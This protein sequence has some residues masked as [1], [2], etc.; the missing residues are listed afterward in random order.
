VR[1]GTA[2][3]ADDGMFQ[4][5][6][7]ILVVDDDPTW[8][9]IV[10]RVLARA[11]CSVA[12]ANN[13]R[14]ALRMKSFL[15]SVVVSD[16][17][18]RLAEGPETRADGSWRPAIAV[19]CDRA[20]LVPGL[21]GA[22]RIFGEADLLECALS[23]LADAS[24]SRPVPFSLG[25]LWTLLGFRSRFD[26]PGGSRLICPPDSEK[27]SRVASD[28]VIASRGWVAFSALTRRRVPLVAIVL[29]SLLLV[30][31]APRLKGI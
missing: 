9:R 22:F 29:A 15:P 25:R 6:S 31:L 4:R 19:T 26:E 7:R 10:R 12:T 27:S 3:A 23:A 28:D 2:I 30:R 1:R 14:G 21:P 5:G 24:P 17:N 11:G 16:E 20:R 8:R 13:D 18:L